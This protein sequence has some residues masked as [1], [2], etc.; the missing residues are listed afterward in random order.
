[1]SLTLGADGRSECEDYPVIFLTILQ[2]FHKVER[3]PLEF[4]SLSCSIFFPFPK[5]HLPPPFGMQINGHHLKNMSAPWP[6]ALSRRVWGG[7]VEGAIL[8]LSADY[9]GS[10]SNSKV[11]PQAMV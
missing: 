1:M 10:F 4:V 6:E 8:S 3:V 5:H 9:L 2:F 11:I 7:C